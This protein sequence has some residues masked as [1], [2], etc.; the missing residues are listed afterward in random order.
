[1]EKS[2]AAKNIVHKTR[3]RVSIGVEHWGTCELIITK[4]ITSADGIFDCKGIITNL[5]W[6]LEQTYMLNVMNIYIFK[7]EPWVLNP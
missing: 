1:M 6:K 7:N 4:Q 5:Q 2:G 3:A